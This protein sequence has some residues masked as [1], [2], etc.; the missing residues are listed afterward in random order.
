MVSCTCIRVFIAAATVWTILYGG[1]G[2]RR[3]GIEHRAF[4]GAVPSGGFSAYLES[5]TQLLH[6]TV[7]DR[8][9]CWEPQDIL[10]SSPEVAGFASFT[11]F[12]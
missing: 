3:C 1:G 5:G 8:K 2:K 4:G 10:P 12:P 9:T 11:S 6:R 7:S